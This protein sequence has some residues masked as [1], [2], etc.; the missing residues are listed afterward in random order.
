MCKKFNILT[1]DF[2]VEW[3]MKDQLSIKNNCTNYVPTT[4]K[5]KMLENRMLHYSEGTHKHMFGNYSIGNRKKNQTK[6]Y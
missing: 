3:Y 6:M 4:L 5:C 2:S 1:E